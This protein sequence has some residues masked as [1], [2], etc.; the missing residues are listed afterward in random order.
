MFPEHV[1]FREHIEVTSHP[2]V[3]GE[4]SGRQGIVLRQVS[5]D[6]CEWAGNARHSRG[7]MR[8]QSRGPSPRRERL[9]HD[10]GQP[11]TNPKLK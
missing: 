5:G 1:K 10:S 11:W 6:G 3:G 7:E 9:W 2:A 8:G 4:E